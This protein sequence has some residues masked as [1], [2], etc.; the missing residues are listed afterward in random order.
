MHTIEWYSEDVRGDISNENTVCGRRYQLSYDGSNGYVFYKTEDN[1]IPNSIIAFGKFND[2]EIALI[3]ESTKLSSKF[4][5]VNNNNKKSIGYFND[6]FFF[7]W[8]RYNTYAKNQSIFNKNS[9]VE[10][11]FEIYRVYNNIDLTINVNTTEKKWYK[12]VYT[13]A[14]KGWIDTRDI[15]DWEFILSAFMCLHRHIEFEIQYSS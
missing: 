15:P 5:I 4:T 7:R 9:A 2:I 12:N 10:L 6:G 1:S 3:N 8:A 14:I 13:T 11:K